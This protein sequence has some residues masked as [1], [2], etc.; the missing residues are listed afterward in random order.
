[1][2][3]TRFPI[4]L[5]IRQAV[6]ATLSRGAVTRGAVTRGA[7]TRVAV[8]RVVGAGALALALAVGAG[9][10]DARAM[11]PH[12]AV[13]ELS[14]AKVR[15]TQAANAISGRMVFTWRDV[16]DG[17]SIDY[18]SRMQI[19]FPQGT[20][21]V[22]WRY[23][24]WESKDGERFRFFTRRLAGAEPERREGEASLTQGAGGTA[25]F[26]RP[27]NRTVE[28][29]GDTMFPLHHSEAVIDRAQAG[30]TFFW[31]HVFDGTGEADGLFGV[32]AVVTREIPA[33]EDLPLDHALLRD[34]SS[35]RVALAYFP[36]GSREATPE[37]E[38]AT[39]LFANGVAGSIRIDYG[40]FVV[41]AELA[42]LKRL[43][44]E[45]CE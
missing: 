40:D 43:E 29:P 25:T 3:K 33:N 36:G 17:W 7:V 28:L 30:D 15:S 11:V 9:P 23:S 8:S 5:A 45:A 12:E 26:A 42:E 31:S 14:L 27:D 39:R 34:Q 24:A 21:E 19:S 22:G 20:R 44:A 35:W 38:Q 2:T 13:Y 41:R 4:P 16:C 32:S 18:R 37:S 1:M 6:R 10:A